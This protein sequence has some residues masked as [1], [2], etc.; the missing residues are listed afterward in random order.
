VDGLI[1]VEGNPLAY[2]KKLPRGHE[3]SSDFIARLE[4]V[5]DMYCYSL[6]R[7]IS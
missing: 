7:F 4:V 3:Y 5:Q 2:Q 1:S 6:A